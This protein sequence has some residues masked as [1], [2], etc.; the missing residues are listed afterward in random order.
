MKRIILFLLLV[1]SLF[2]ETLKLRTIENDIITLK[3]E[4]KQFKF[5]D[6]SYKKKNILLFFFGTLCPYCIKEIP[7]L[8]ELDKQYDNL[9]ILGIHA[10]HKISDKDLKKFLKKKKIDFDV[11]SF[12]DGIRIVNRLNDL[13]LWIGAVPYNLLVD[14]NTNL[15]ALEI[16]QIQPILDNQIFMSKVKLRYDDIND[17][18]RSID[19]TKVK[20]D[21][22]DENGTV[23]AIN[24]SQLKFKILDKND[25]YKS[26]DIL[27]IK[28]KKQDINKTEVQP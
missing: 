1:S 7:D 6:K 14:A 4:G 21:W 25:T 24:L 8:K 18:N 9:K 16:N 17:T 22:V 3:A 5:V 26:I 28:F 12:D 13:K 20:L 2:A 23:R 15:N 19:N 27:E 10:Q 11:L